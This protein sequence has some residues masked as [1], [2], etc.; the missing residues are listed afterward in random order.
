M[1]RVSSSG[2]PTQWKATLSPAPLSTCRSTQFQAA[3]ILP[4]TNHLANGGLSQSRTWSHLVSQSRRS[5]CFSQK[6]SR[7]FSASSYASAVRLA[8]FANS[9][10]G[11]NRRSSWARLAKVPLDS[12]LID[13]SSCT[14]SGCWGL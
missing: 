14:G 1:S 8:F 9:A 10:G 2:S 7:S 11:S 13:N 4:P 5:A 6:A 12:S 3:L